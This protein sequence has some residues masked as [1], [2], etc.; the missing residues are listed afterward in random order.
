MRAVPQ[1]M[2]DALVPGLQVALITDGRVEVLPFG[3]AD[4]RSRRPV[5]TES[6]FEAASLGKPVFAYG[7][8]RLA[9]EGRIDLDAPVG[10]YLANLPVGVADATPRQLLSHT[11]G[12]PNTPPANGALTRQQLPAPRFSYSGEGFKLLQKVVEQVTGQDLQQYM[13]TAVFDP[14]GMTSS[15]YV[16][17]DDHAERKAFGHSVTGSSAGRNRIADARAASSLETTAADYARFLMAA[18]RGAGLSPRIAGQLLRPEVALEEGCVTCLG[19][20]PG[21]AFPGLHWGLGFGL[22]QSGGGSFAWH[23]GDNQTMQ[24]YAAVSTDG[25]R[26]VVILANSAN[27]HSIA[28]EIASSVLGM[29]APGYQWIGSYASHRDPARRLL[30]RMVRRGLASLG[31]EDLDLPRAD[32]LQ[33]ATWLAAGERPAEAAALLRRLIAAGDSTAEDHVLL[34]DALRRQGLYRE[35]SD[36]ANAALRTDPGNSRARLALERIEQSKREIHPAALA[37]FAGVYSSPYGPLEIRSDGRRLTANLLDQPASEMLP[38]SE[39]AFLM[40]AM[41]VPIEFV[42]DQN[43]V[44]THAVVRAGGEIRVQRANPQR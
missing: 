20:P 5:T 2:Q 30:G 28:R 31:P 10:R 8:L 32:A 37:R 40:E 12:L 43:G 7:V 4:V 22:A 3:M 35:A 15:S 1:L 25:R 19:R 24:S 38:L 39:N 26:G 41:N 42:E 23:W 13:K 29:D 6:V 11:A 44:V 16:W 33:V 27:G 21:Q 14:L 36:A 17:R 18:I 9:S 34:A